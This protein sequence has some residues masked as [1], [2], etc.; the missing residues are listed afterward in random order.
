MEKLRDRD[1]GQFKLIAD[2]D[3][4]GDQPQAI[5]KLVQGLNAKRRHRCCSA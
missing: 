3:P 4:Q 1:N 2:F 5:E